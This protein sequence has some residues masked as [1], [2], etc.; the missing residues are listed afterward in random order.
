M[1]STPKSSRALFGR[2]YFSFLHKK[3][4][5]ICSFSSLHCA[6]KWRTL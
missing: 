4:I 5:K 3:I 2:G 1:H 6:H